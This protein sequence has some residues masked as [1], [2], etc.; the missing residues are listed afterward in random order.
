MRGNIIPV[1]EVKGLRRQMQCYECIGKSGSQQFVQNN[2][3]SLRKRFRFSVS[4]GG[5]FLFDFFTDRFL[6]LDNF[7]KY[8]DFLTFLDELLTYHLTIFTYV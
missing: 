6:L 4:P 1:A 7:R 8:S 3:D 5:T 2:P